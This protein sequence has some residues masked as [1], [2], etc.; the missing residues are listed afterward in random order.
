MLC[1]HAAVVRALHLLL[2]LVLL[3]TL[4][5]LA[6]RAAGLLQLLLQACGPAV[7]GA[8]AGPVA[9]YVGA[10]ALLFLWEGDHRQQTAEGRM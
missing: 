4:W 1:Q 7:A 8:A 6:A 3:H 10:A 2:L 9:G 5:A